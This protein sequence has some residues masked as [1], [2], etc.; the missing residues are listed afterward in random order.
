MRASAHS[1]SS[2]DIGCISEP[3]LC[4]SFLAL[5]CVALLTIAIH[6]GVANAHHN[7]ISQA[8]ADDHPDADTTGYWV[9][10]CGAAIRRGYTGARY[11]NPFAPGQNNQ[12]PNPPAGLP[13]DFN[14]HSAWRMWDRC[15]QGNAWAPNGELYPGGSF[16]V[17]RNP[18]NPIWFNSNS[19]GDGGPHYSM[20]VV[21]Q[22]KLR[23]S[24]AFVREEIV[25]MRADVDAQGDYHSIMAPGF[26]YS[27]RDASVDPSA[28]PNGWRAC[29]GAGLYW[30]GNINFFGFEE[31]W[32]GRY[33]GGEGTGFDLGEQG[34]DPDEMSRDW[35]V[36]RP[37]GDGYHK[38]DITH[39]T[40]TSSP[41][42]FGLWV[43]CPNY[44]PEEL[45]R[46]DRL[47]VCG[48]GAIDGNRAHSFLRSAQVR[49]R[50][51]DNPVVENIRIEHFD[52]SVVSAAGAVA[53][54]KTTR[55]ELIKF[56][57]SDGS[58]I[59]KLR[60][61]IDGHDYSHALDPWVREY[62]GT[63]TG[64][65]REFTCRYNYSIP[66]ANGNGT[67]TSLPHAV[68]P[69]MW[70]NFLSGYVF[71]WDSLSDGNHE[72]CITA[73]DV[74]RNPAA[75]VNTPGSGKT[76]ACKT[77]VVN[78]P[79]IQ[80]KC[81]NLNSGGSDT[82]QDFYTGT[83]K[84]CD[85]DPLPEPATSVE[86]PENNEST[87]FDECS[88]E[89]CDVFDYTIIDSSCKVKEHTLFDGDDGSVESVDGIKYRN[90]IV[91]VTINLNAMV[92]IS[93]QQAKQKL[94]TTVELQPRNTTTYRQAL[95]CS[96]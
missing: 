73:W 89:S 52:N 84:R 60:L 38:L 24:H 59:R 5:L 6:P 88:G 96:E 16:G 75:A 53:G 50:D 69:D 33:W 1:T 72:V 32:N 22:D 27:G 86:P 39:P 77:F 12:D 36:R 46:D 28:A 30:E 82:L 95:G 15:E 7:E 62:E 91:A 35:C 67:Y 93:D 68:Q 48:T 10:A 85:K 92:G 21:D 90:R 3:V 42:A 45:R 47:G 54:D 55:K 44:I 4:R 9:Y 23:I 19:P 49:I 11:N 18:E 80:M 58:G 13:G 74:K 78:T 70:K 64:W 63:A 71:D 26:V 66:C 41:K 81:T 20:H 34:H 57:A 87:P 94:R 31:V 56:D 76:T 51:Y 17:A 65:D 25:G 43:S 61:R 79:P 2:V 8:V 37:S 14:A 29:H 83:A 40:H